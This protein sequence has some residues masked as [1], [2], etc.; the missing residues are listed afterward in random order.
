MMYI[1]LLTLISDT[2]ESNWQGRVMGV[3]AALSSITWGIGPLLTGGLNFYGV[4][5]AFLFCT[6]LL[7]ISIFSL[8]KL[9]VK[10]KSIGFARTGS[11]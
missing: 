3:V 9:T 10:S 6:A 4:G 8:R 7:I 2:T 11:Q 5:I 1:A